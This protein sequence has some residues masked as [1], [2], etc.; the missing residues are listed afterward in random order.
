MVEITR[1]SVIE[2][3]TTVWGNYVEE[4]RKLSPAEQQEFMKRQGYARLAD[5]VAHFT[6]WW[7]LAMNVIAIKQ[8]DPAYFFPDINVDEFNAAAV[9]GAKDLSEEQVLNKFEQ[10][11]LRFVECVKNLSDV[12]LENPNIIRQLEIDVFG[13]LGEHAIK[14]T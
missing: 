2:S 7:E 9:E 5:L 3:L 13:H 12:D 8:K 1:K 10:T 11:R 14:K 4:Y 6:A